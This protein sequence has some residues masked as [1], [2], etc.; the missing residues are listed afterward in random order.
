MKSM[1]P[2]L[3]QT[4]RNNGRFGKMM[5]I[6]FDFGAIR[7]KFETRAKENNYTFTYKING[8][9]LYKISKR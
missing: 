9:G 2:T 3:K 4:D 8:I 5:I 6:T 1:G 7:K